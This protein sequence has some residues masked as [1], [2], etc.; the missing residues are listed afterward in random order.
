MAVSA[1]LISKTLLEKL[2]VSLLTAF[3]LKNI[4]AYR[5]ATALIYYGEGRG[6]KEIAIRLGIS[7]KT[8]VN[9]VLK[10]MSGGVDCIMSKHYCGR[11]RK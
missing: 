2:R 11:G 10:F 9:W 5:L 7:G 6:I 4:Q 3:K 8:V 1:I